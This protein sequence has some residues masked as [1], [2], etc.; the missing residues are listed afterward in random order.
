[1]S[2]PP[3][4]KLN[5]TIPPLPTTRRGYGIQLNILPK[6]ERLIYCNG[7]LVVLRSLS[8]P[9]DCQLFTEHK[10]NVTVATPSPS[11]TWVASGDD[12]GNVL[13]WSYPSL[14]L[15]AQYKVGKTVADIDWDESSTR[16]VCAGDG[17]QKAKVISFDSGNSL[18][19]ITMHNLPI[20][21]CSYRKVRPFRVAT[22]S[23]DLTV[24]LYEGPPFK[25]K[26]SHK[27]HARYPNVVRYSPDGGLLVSAGADSRLVLYD[28]KTGEVVREVD[29]GVE[30]GHKAAIYALAWS[31][32]SKQVATA[33]G[34]KQVKV[35]DVAEGKV[36]HTY[37]FGS[38]IDDMQVGVAWSAKHLVSV[39]LSGAINYLDPTGASTTPTRSLHGHQSTIQAMTLHPS[40]SSFY[41]A[42]L[43]GE[44]TRW[45]SD[46]E[47]RWLTGKG[48]GAKVVSALTLSSTHLH[49]F[50][51]DDCMRVTDLAHAEISGDGIALGGLP[52]AAVTTHVGLSVAVLAQD[53]AV[54]LS[55]TKVEATLPLSYTPTTVALSRDGRVVAVSGKDKKLYLYT[56]TTSPTPTLTPLHTITTHDKPVTSISFAP[57]S[58]YLVSVDR[59]AS[60]Y[61]HALEGGGYGVMN[62]SGWRFHQA[63]VQGVEWGPGGQW[64][65]TVGLDNALIVW[66]DVQGFDGGKRVKVASAHSA[67]VDGVHWWDAST[68]LTYASD[69]TIKRWTV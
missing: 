8:S 51:L 50:G 64:V 38:A 65:V 41:T 26:E 67:G 62:K 19:E 4:P 36:L 55:L 18:G 34:N 10:A 16:L 23:E 17:A 35:W 3:E 46:G 15:K 5:L 40:T 56:L 63:G 60:V 31:P 29:E 47:G 45:S 58:P 42:G 1:M 11:Q 59:E 30:G 54:L 24:N 43:T 66:G 61:I 32:D 2:V 21:S 44:V 53:K 57:S 37:T 6:D 48:H 14:K 69:R 28:G 52:V 12:D 22:A 33:A 68:F 27:K 25:Y 7:R 49:S 20:I 39:S 13:I 9:S